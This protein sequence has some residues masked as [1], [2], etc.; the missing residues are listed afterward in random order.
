M[1][2]LHVTDCCILIALYIG[3]IIEACPPSDSV[4]AL[5]TDLLI[6]PDGNMSILSTSDQV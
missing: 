6:E 2:L 5:T 3:G 4:T 1:N